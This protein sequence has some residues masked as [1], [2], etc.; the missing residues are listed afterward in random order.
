MAFDIR[1]LDTLS[2]DEAE[3]LL[4]D[5]INGLLKQFVASEIGQAYVE[6]HTEGGYWIGTFIEMSYLY[7]EMTLPKMTKAKV[8]EVMEYL[9]PRKL[10]L[11]DP[12][13][14]NDAIPELVAFWTFLKQTYKL[15][16]AGAIAKYLTSIEDQFQGWMF[17]SS[18]GGLAKNFMMQGM[19]AGHDMTTQEGMAAF[20][21]EFNKQLEAGSDA[22]LPL[23][24]VLSMPE[25]PPDITA[26][27]EHLG[28][29]VPKEGQA[30]DPA[31]LLGQLMS[32]VDQLE[33][34]EAAEEGMALEAMQGQAFPTS[35]F[36]PDFSRSLRAQV[37]G[38]T[39]DVSLPKEAIALLKNQAISN[40]EPGTILQ[41][42]QMLLDRIEAGELTVSGKRQQFPMKLLAELNQNFSNPITLD[43]KRP[44]QQSYPPIHGLYLLLQAT[45][46]TKIVAQGKKHKLE[47]NPEI[48]ASWQQLNP[49]ERYCTL[50]EA[51]LIRSHP[52]MLGDDRSGYFNEGNF[53]LQGWKKIAE[54]K[55]KTYKNYQEQQDLNYWPRLHNLALMELFG[56]IKIT[57]G[58][59]E[60]GKGWRV[61]GVASLAWGEALMPLIVGAYVEVGMMWPSETDP[62]LPFNELQP[63]LQPYLSNW[64][65]SLAVPHATFNPG[66]HMFKVSVVRK[67]SVWRRIAV[68]G[69]ATL[70]VLGALILESVGFDSD[71]LDQFTYRNELGRKVRVL[72]PHAQEDVSTNELRVG[73]LPLSEGSVMEYLFDFGDNWEF[74]VVLES[75]EAVEAVP[76]SEQ[77]QWK[78]KT[79]SKSKRSQRGPRKQLGEILESHGESPTQ[80]PDY[81]KDWWD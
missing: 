76:E 63:T 78:A 81:G 27:L 60:K 61:R 56:L 48:Y 51:W 65:Q 1:L 2:Y 79:K 30:V 36:D 46:I 47:L 70:D 18:R 32:A 5:Y 17:D 26:M 14:T 45:G 8:Q 69:E 11:M 21:A 66:R 64:Q 50:M 52:E 39:G 53:V 15:R 43:L 25:T 80:Y 54:D 59:P 40:T 22:T 37:M 13:E 44:Q 23:P 57:S 77:G 9:L 68:A 4:G 62:T 34:L 3:P 28:V 74:E 10:T 55:K 7:G 35:G 33:A 72:H 20:Q 12:S 41:D 67:P 75:I 38:I 58:K 29:D 71:H 6:T 31:M 16:S 42:F 73:I 24:K 49:T 19:Q